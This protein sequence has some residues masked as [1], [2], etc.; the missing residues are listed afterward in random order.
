MNAS[1][2]TYGALEG[3]PSKF[4]TVS[5]GAPSH[6]FSKGRANWE[7]PMPEVTVPA[8]SKGSA[9]N[10]IRSISA[11]DIVRIAK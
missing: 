4:P 5:E 1:S 6:Q 8:R 7:I 3:K 11:S 9:C 10:E 2:T